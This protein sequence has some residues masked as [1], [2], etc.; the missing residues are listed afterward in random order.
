MFQPEAKLQFVRR[1]CPPSDGWLVY[2]DIDASEEGRTGGPRTTAES[3]EIQQ[4]MQKEGEAACAELKQLE[5]QVG[6]CRA[7]WSKKHGLPRIEGDR[8]IVAFHRS[9]WRCLIAEVEAE[10]T[11]QPEQKLYKA[12]GQLVMAVSQI[13]PGGWKLEFV[14]A[15]HGAKISEHLRRATSLQK[16]RISALSLAFDHHHDR[17]LF[18]AEPCPQSQ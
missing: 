15:V 2:V 9:S 10:S 7:E 8:D 14:L 13:Q 16:L 11:G 6:K 18:R 4:R 12:I 5:V 1:Y 17:W 3:R